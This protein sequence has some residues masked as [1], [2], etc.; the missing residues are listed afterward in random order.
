MYE[1]ISY[2]A[3]SSAAI[4]PS[5]LLCTVRC[6]LQQHRRRNVRAQNYSPRCVFIDEGNKDLLYAFVNY[7]FEHDYGA[8]LDHLFELKLVWLASILQY[9][10]RFI[11]K[12]GDD[13]VLVKVLY[14]KSSHPLFR[15]PLTQLIDWGK[16]VDD[17]R[18]MR[19]AE[20]FNY[21]EGVESNA[22]LIDLMI[23]QR[24]THEV[25]LRKLEGDIDLFKRSVL[26]RLDQI[27]RTNSEILNTLRSMKLDSP[28]RFVRHA[29]PSPHDDSSR[30]RRRVAATNEE[31]PVPVPPPTEPSPEK[32][33]AVASNLF[34][35]TTT[36][37]YTAIACVD[38]YLTFKLKAVS[39]WIDPHKSQKHI[40]SIVTRITTFY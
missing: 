9:L 10:E 16:L 13:H 36:Q 2:Q 23:K 17:D 32:T 29:S 3:L 6:S 30:K 22:I 27:D 35:R 15:I 8:K 31:G 14:E 1:A 33:P 20:H 18:R 7:L 24:E 39:S 28:S 38:D 40:R 26:Q 19:N 37:N 5:L 12:Y 4:S 21:T 25:R 11:N 34:T